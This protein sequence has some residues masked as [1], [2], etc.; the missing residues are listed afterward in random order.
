MGGNHGTTADT[1]ARA[2]D[3]PYRGAEQSLNKD[4]EPPK[5]KPSA[6]RKARG[7]RVK[8]RPRTTQRSNQ[9][10]SSMRNVNTIS[11]R[12]NQVCFQSVLPAKYQMR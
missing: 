1:Q 4:R 6:K 10:K 11:R 5:A 8:P 9:V 12:W 3:R 2:G 7:K